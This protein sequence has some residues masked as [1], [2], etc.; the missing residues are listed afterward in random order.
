M[1]V[2]S[3]MAILC[4]LREKSFRICCNHWLNCNTS[5]KWTITI[6]FFGCVEWKQ[7]Q[8]LQKNVKTMV[9]FLQI[10]PKADPMTNKLILLNSLPYLDRPCEGSYVRTA[11]QL[12]SIQSLLLRLYFSLFYHIIA[13]EQTKSLACV[14]RLDMHQWFHKDGDHK[15]GWAAFACCSLLLDRFHPS[16][17][18]L[19]SDM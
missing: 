15:P 17:M 10:L 14:W 8:L 13:H 2:D 19:G 18:Y 1:V 11:T 7:L 12:C 3:I 5:A 6:K 4:I 16:A 9:S